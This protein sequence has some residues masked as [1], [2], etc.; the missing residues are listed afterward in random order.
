VR[1]RRDLREEGRFDVLVRD[2]NLGGLEAG[3]EPGLDEILTLD[4][5]QP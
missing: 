2:E 4:R 5:E 1:E 3:I